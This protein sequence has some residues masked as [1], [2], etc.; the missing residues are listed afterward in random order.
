MSMDLTSD[1]SEW[2]VSDDFNGSDHKT[3]T[4][5]LLISTAPLD[6]VWN[7]KKA[8]WPKFKSLLEKSYIRIPE[9]I[10]E[11]RVEY[12]LEKIYKHIYKAMEKT[13]PKITPSGKQKCDKWYDEKLR[14]MRNRLSK[15]K[16]RYKRKPSDRNY[17]E[18]LDTVSELSLIHI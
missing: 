4:A 6:P 16:R 7:W 2:E 14:N 1:I 11:R 10:N 12:L 5:K 8:E 3:I 9:K 18:Y 15:L 13:I 17:T